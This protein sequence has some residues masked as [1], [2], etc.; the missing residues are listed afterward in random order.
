[1]IAIIGLCIILILALTVIRVG[2]IALE[3]N[4]F[5]DGCRGFSGTIDVLKCWL[6]NI[7]VGINC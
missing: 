1:M 6:H 3:L 4:R 2:A 7:R 5:V